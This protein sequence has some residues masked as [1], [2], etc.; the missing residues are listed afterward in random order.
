LQVPDAPPRLLVKYRYNAAGDLTAVYNPLDKAH[1]YHYHNHCLV[2]QT[3]RSGLSFYYTYNETG[4]KGK[5]IRA[6]GDDGLF[7]YRFEYGKG[8]TKVI[9][10]LGFE[11]IFEYD[12]HHLPHKITDH[13]GNVTCFKYDEAGRTSAVI[14]PLQRRTGYVYDRRGNPHIITR[15]DGSS[16]CFIYD[17]QHRP[18][19]II[20]PNGG[21]WRQQWDDKN[22]LIKQ[23]SPRNAT[24]CYSYNDH[25]DLVTVTDPYGAV[26]R[27][28][29]D[30]YGNTVRI[31]DALGKWVGF[32]VDEL[33][34]I[35]SA[36]DLQNK[37]VKSSL[38]SFD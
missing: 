16:I 15:S 2:K 9:N 31:T 24:T 30:E 25:G 4:P 13:Q 28:E 20:D 37:G 34:N 6:R 3:Y 26:T 27:Y 11:Q 10:S 18:V 5:C 7:D 23:I 21:S 36:F 19:E 1:R 38:D 33:G 14:D 32:T 12:R 35:I 17:D 29:P 8:R 22:R